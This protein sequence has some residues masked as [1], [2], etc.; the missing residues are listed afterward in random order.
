MAAINEVKQGFAALNDGKSKP[1]PIQLQLTAEVLILRREE[2]IP[3]GHEENTNEIL[4]KLRTIVIH[5]EHLG[6]LGLSV[7]GGAEHRLPVL[8]SKIIPDQAAAKTEQ[9]FVGDAIL[10][11]NDQS[12][13]LC[14]HDEVVDIL[15]NAGD[16]VTLTVQHFKPASIFLNKGSDNSDQLP[17]ASSPQ[18]I[19]LPRL[20]KQWVIYSSIP[21]LFAYLTRY[22]PGTDKLRTSAFEVVGI[23]GASTGVIQMDDSHMFAEWIT[24]ITNNISTLLN[25]MIRM[26]NRLLLPEEQI[27][28]M[29]WVQE[30]VSPGHHKQAWKFK[31]V[32]LK[33]PEVFFFDIPPMQSRDWVRC[34]T[35]FRVYECMFKV[36]QDS[37]L[38]DDRQHCCTIQTGSKET[39]YFSLES[40]SDLLHL[41]KAWYRTNHTSVMRLKSRT[42][43]CT[44]RGRLSGLTLDLDVGFSLYDS[45][46]KMLEQLPPA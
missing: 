17:S 13:E 19:N 33:G 15:K 6:G 26:M 5:K 35:V 39:M 37:E 14:T 20:E 4:N 42:F 16:V 8:I 7:K 11:V 43:G 36:L 2:L 22:F 41:E 38:L 25:Q 44:W 24:S 1:Q 9:L 27:M 32:A 12:V 3:V 31:F 28:Y 21:L 30:R 34:D 18:C 46:T 10:K 29:G 45:E 23:D 40:R